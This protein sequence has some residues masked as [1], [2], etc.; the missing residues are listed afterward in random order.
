MDAIVLLAHGSR[1]PLWRKPMEAV[2]ARLQ[3]QKPQRL[4]CCAYLELCPP[5]LD[6]AITQ[7]AA[8]GVTHITIAPLFLGAGH[9]VRE[10]VP[11]KIKRLA[12]VFPQLHL[13]LL[14]PVGQDE[15]LVTLLAQLASEG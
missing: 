9:H 15:R 12:S 8:N 13:H 6:T 7:L 14:P 11:R 2:Q 3:A 5:D 4:V 1:D 10:D